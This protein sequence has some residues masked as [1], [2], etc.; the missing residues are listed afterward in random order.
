[1]RSVTPIPPT[2]P[3][4]KAPEK[5]KQ[6]C[7]YCGSRFDRGLDNCPNCG[8]GVSQ[9]KPE[10]TP[11]SGRGTPMKMGPPPAPHGGSKIR[12]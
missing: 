11:R 12:V 2:P 5:A 6:F 9:S 8:A 10:P 4:P 3:R 1:M 7:A